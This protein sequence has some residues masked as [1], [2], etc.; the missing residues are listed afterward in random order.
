MVIESTTIHE[1]LLED[2]A[3]RVAI[4]IAVNP[5]AHLPISIGDKIVYVQDAIN[6]MVPWPKHLVFNSTGKVKILLV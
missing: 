2:N 5:E 4:K 3:Y 1:V 6:I